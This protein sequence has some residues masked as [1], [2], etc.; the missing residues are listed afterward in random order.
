[1]SQALSF[2]YESNEAYERLVGQ[3]APFDARYELLVF[4]ASVGYSRGTPAADAPVDDPDGT[5]DSRQP[6]EMRWNY[7]DQ[8]PHLSVVTASLA[9]ADTG[10]PKAILSADQQIETLVSYGAAGSRIIYEEVISSGGDDLDS[11]VDF[12]Q[13]HRDDDRVEKQTG[14]LEQLEDEISSL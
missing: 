4:A 10:E 12:V 1:M 14:V 7:I 5:D 11:L 2:E 3:E 9:Y 6:K 13:E 8:N